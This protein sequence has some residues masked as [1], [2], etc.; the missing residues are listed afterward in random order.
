ME[1]LIKLSSRTI[2]LNRNENLNESGRTDTNLYFIESGSLRAYVRGDGVEHN[3][4]FAYAGNFMASL[5]SFL[6]NTPSAFTT[7]AIKRSVLRVVTRAQFLEHLAAGEADRRAWT[8]LLE[9]LVLQQLEREQDLLTVSPKER[10]LRVLKRSPRLFQ[11]IPH[12]HIANYLR[13]S[14][15]TLSRLKKS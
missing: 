10:Y 7:Q 12:R 13:M 15:E 5:D 8:L 4:R 1:Q 6:R 2:T 14:P 9:T 3:I 11:E